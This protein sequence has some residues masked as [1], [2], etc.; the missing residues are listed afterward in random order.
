[1][2]EVIPITDDGMGPL[3]YFCCAVS[4]E[5]RNR[6]EAK[7]IAIKTPEMARWV[8]E[9]RDNGKNPFAGV[10][11]IDPLCKHGVCGCDIC[12]SECS[13]CIAEA[14]AECEGAREKYGE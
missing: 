13:E 14:D 10:S 9:A 8:E 12:R 1:M 3:E 6:E 4:V 11:V 7:R 5:A 2:N